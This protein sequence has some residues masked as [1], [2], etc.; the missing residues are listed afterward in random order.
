[1]VSPSAFTFRLRGCAATLD[2]VAIRNG[3]AQA[4][5]DVQPDDIRI[6]SLATALNPWELPPTKI[7]TLNFA[8]L[9]SVIEARIQQGEWKLEGHGLDC[10]LILDTHFIG[11]TPL[12]DVEAPKH[13]YE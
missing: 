9:P 6:Q 1:M 8:K 2:E 5:G 7:A 11:L 12:N 10:T 3:L 4:F 13:D